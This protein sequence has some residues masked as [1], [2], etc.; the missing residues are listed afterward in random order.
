MFSPGAPPCLP[1]AA[2]ATFGSRR[3]RPHVVP[4]PSPGRPRLCTWGR[5]RSSAASAGLH[6]SL[7]PPRADRFGERLVVAVVLAGVVLGEVRPRTVEG[8]AL[9]Q[10]GG[11]RHRGAGGGVGAG[12]GA[13]A[14]G[15]GGG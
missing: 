11:G 8:G 12:Q 2:T 3:G 6:G 14:R 4:R 1:S 9:P 7:D 10:G 13:P 15:G 5:P